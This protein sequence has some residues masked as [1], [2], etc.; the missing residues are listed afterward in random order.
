MADEGNKQ[1]NRTTNVNT[2]AS[3]PV[4]SQDTTKEYVVL[5]LELS[6]LV[7]SASGN[8]KHLKRVKRWSTIKLTDEHART[9]LQEPRPAVM[10][11]SD[12]DKLMKQR[13]EGS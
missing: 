7:P 9:L 5:D 6:M 3:T 11:K 2:S 13:N 12:Y 4:T 10:L 8:N 1:E